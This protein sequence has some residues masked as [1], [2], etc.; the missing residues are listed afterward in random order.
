MLYQI[1]VLQNRHSKW[2]TGKI[3]FL[4]G[5]W[6]LT[7]KAPG[8]AGAFFKSSSIIEDWV[9]LLRQLYSAC[10]HRV[11]WFGGLTRKTGGRELASKGKNGGLGSEA[12]WGVD[13]EAGFSA[14]RLTIRL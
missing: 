14:A 6:V 7:A 1:S 12:V 9:E 11:R 4:K 2:V 3:V 10:F 5:L 8:V 13:R